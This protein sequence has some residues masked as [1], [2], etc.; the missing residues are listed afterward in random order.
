MVLTKE[1]SLFTVNISDSNT[2]KSSWSGVSKTKEL[3]VIAKDIHEAS[4]KALQFIESENKKPQSVLDSEGGL[5]KEP[6]IIS[7]STISS[8]KCELIY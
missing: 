3:V 6:S 5:I 8:I 7:I 2:L 4:I 1:H